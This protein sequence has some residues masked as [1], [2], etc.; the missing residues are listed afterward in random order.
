[1]D[2]RNI[3]TAPSKPLPAWLRHGYLIICVIL[4]GWDLGWRSL[5]GWIGGHENLS[6]VLVAL[7]LNH[8][9]FRYDWPRPVRVILRCTASVWIAFTLGHWLWQFRALLGAGSP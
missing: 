1:M 2:L 3:L 4:L 5:H 9:A 6:R 8:L 7:P